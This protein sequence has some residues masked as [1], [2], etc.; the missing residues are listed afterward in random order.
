MRRSTPK[1]DNTRTPRTEE[2][3]DGGVRGCRRDHPGAA[4]Q[5]RVGNQAVMRLA[6]A[7]PSAGESARPG[8]VSDLPGDDPAGSDRIDGPPAGSVGRPLSS[9]RR[10]GM[11][12]VFGADFGDVRVHDGVGALAATRQLDAAAYATDTDIVVRPDLADGDDTA[13]PLFAHEL[14]H[15]AQFQRAKGEQTTAG[16]THRRDGAEREAARAAPKVAAGE[17]VRVS[18]TPSAPVATFGLDWIEETARDVG[19]GAT[20]AASSAASTVGSAAQSAGS[21]VGS[22]ARSAGSA[23]GSAAQSVGSTVA[24]GASTAWD[25]AKSA[26]STVASGVQ[27]AASAT[28]DA[29]WGTV[30][31][32]ADM[33]VEHGGPLG[34]IQAGMQQNAQ[35]VQQGS[36]WLQG[37][38]DAGQDWAAGKIQGAADMA[39][40]IPGLAQAADAGA[41][42]FDQ[43][44]GLQSGFLQGATTAVGDVATMAANPVA[45]GTGIYQMAKHAP[46]PIGAMNPIKSAE[47]GYDLLTG[48]ASVGEY[49]NQMFMPGASMREDAQFWRQ[50]AGGIV[51]PYR[52]SVG[53]DGDY[54]QA[55]GRG[56]FDIGGLV[57]SGGGS[58]AAKGA[59]TGG[60]IATAV[61]RGSRGAGIAGKVDDIATSGTRMSDDVTRISGRGD[62]PGKGRITNASDQ[63]L[64]LSDAMK[65]AERGMLGEPIPFEGSTVKRHS[66][67]DWRNMSGQYAGD[68]SQLW[69]S[70]RSGGSR[71]T[72]YRGPTPEPWHGGTRPGF[73]T[74]GLGENWQVGES[75][76]NK[77]ALGERVQV[78]HPTQVRA[79]EIQRTPPSG[80]PFYNRQFSEDIGEVGVQAETAAGRPHAIKSGMERSRIRDA[81]A[82]GDIASEGTL[83]H[84]T[85]KLLSDV[86]SEAGGYGNRAAVDRALLSHQS[87]KHASGPAPR[88]GG[89]PRTLRQ[90]D[91]ELRQHVG[92]QPGAIDEL[93]QALE[94]ADGL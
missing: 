63:T 86:R 59:G 45:A 10:R 53:E 81:V 69:R 16:V 27:S 83:M 74:R 91:V 77:S 9:E 11:E 70:S 47:A 26:G 62:T 29:Y 15:V 3:S 67:G 23:V 14:A 79:G 56:I 22:A 2:E 17:S 30:D 58:A 75:V 1:E 55:V 92:A 82:S 90:T 89:A 34:A 71:S 25:G 94:A 52:R 12:H 72:D 61:G 85:R 41:W 31:A 20:S 73:N 51:D 65:R 36:Q 21:A 48:N 5:R 87:A 28:S 68:A 78:D 64:T 93:L 37:K 46:T 60:R 35:Y 13:D 42:A 18:E 66:G 38:I 80:N 76:P 54:A 40:G 8:D 57:L 6:R 49:A 44:T 24:S 7:R 88:A 84:R 39:N 43:Y 50:A 19:S 32:A 33:M 4:L